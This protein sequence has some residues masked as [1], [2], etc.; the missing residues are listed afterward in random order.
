MDTIE[1][2]ID[3]LLISPDP[4]EDAGDLTICIQD[5]MPMV[6]ISQDGRQTVVAATLR[7]ALE[8]ALEARG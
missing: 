6:E 5:D 1:E 8:Q 2:L 3:K 4:D 7:E